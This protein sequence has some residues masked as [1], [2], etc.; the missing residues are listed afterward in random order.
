M[1]SKIEIVTG[2]TIT[3]LF[4]ADLDDEWIEL[5]QLWLDES[6]SS[7]RINFLTAPD[8]EA[9]L[10]PVLSILYSEMLSQL[11]DLTKYPK[12]VVVTIEE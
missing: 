5:I 10:A 12:P 1:E 2:K 3:G 11:F 6:S 7:W 8:G 4:R 9:S